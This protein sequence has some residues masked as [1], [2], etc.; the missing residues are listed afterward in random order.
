MGFLHD[1]LAD[2]HSAQ[3]LNMLDDPNHQGLGLAKNTVQVV[4]LL[5]L[6]NLWMARRKWLPV[7]GSLLP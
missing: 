6:A 3:L 7:T 2:A 5:A 1:Q 4:T